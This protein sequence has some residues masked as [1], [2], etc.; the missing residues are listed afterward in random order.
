MTRQDM[1]LAAIKLTHTLVFGLSVAAILYTLWA[2]LTRTLTPLLWVSVSFPALV[3]LGLKVN[4]DE[5]ILQTWSKR[6]HGSDEWVS[7]I[8]I[9]DWL[10]VRVRPI[11]TPLYAVAVTLLAVRLLWAL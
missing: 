3:W 2:G 1:A 4:N 10:A 9:P 11:F 7:D 6:L 5:C 8:Y